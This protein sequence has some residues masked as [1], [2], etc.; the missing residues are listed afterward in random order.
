MRIPVPPK[1]RLLTFVKDAVI[2]G[3][4]AIIPKKTAPTDVILVRI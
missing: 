3:R 2:L 1:I 4:I